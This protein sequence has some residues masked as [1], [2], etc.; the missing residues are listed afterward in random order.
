MYALYNSE[1]KAVML[2]VFT[3]ECI[4]NRGDDDGFGVEPDEHEVL[5]GLRNRDGDWIEELRLLWI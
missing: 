2:R 3:G 1:K 4:E 5:E